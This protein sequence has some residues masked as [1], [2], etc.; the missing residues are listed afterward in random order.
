[1]KYILLMKRF[2]PPILLAVP[3]VVVESS[4]SSVRI[5]NVSPYNQFTVTCNARAKVEGETLPLELTVYWVRRAGNSSSFVPSTKYITTGSPEDGYRSILNTMEA[6]RENT[7]LYRC[8]ARY[9][10]DRRIQGYSNTALEVEGM[11]QKTASG[12]LIEM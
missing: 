3:S 2:R 12:Y 11:N 1:M 5:P 9:T 10:S 8:A 6:D 4:P 7:V